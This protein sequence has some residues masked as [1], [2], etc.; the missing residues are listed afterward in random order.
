MFVCMHV[1][2]DSLP[3]TDL[4]LPNLHE[5]SGD[6]G[7]SPGRLHGVRLKQKMAFRLLLSPPST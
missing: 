4:V 3:F 2:L 5:L 7:S 1:P 6:L